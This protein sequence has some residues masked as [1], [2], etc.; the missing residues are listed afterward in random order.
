MMS[1]NEQRNVPGQLAVPIWLIQNKTK[2]QD[3]KG[4][5]SSNDFYVVVQAAV[6]LVEKHDF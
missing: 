5:W 3:K 6:F 1:L 2:V 4:H